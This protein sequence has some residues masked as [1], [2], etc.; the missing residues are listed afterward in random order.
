MRKRAKRAWSREN[1]LPIDVGGESRRIAR[2]D[3]DEIDHPGNVV[4]VSGA[5]GTSLCGLLALGG[6][7][8]LSSGAGG[9]DDDAPDE[10]T[11]TIAGLAGVI[12]GALGLLVYVP[13]L[14][15]GDRTGVSVHL[16][17]SGVLVRF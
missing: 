12:P 16:G 15:W 6:G 2:A 17:P 1:H 7:I 14:I 8:V 10:Q 5:V 11:N 4:M 13:Q 9:S 3:V